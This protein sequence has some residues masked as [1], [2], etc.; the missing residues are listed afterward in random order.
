MAAAAIP[1][2]INVRARPT[3]KANERANA[4][5]REVVCAPPTYPT[6]KGTVATLHGPK[7]VKIPP[8]KT[9]R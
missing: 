7:L 9:R 6:I 8:K 2:N 4:R 5:L 3:A 1:N